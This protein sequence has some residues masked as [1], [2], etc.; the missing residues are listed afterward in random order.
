MQITYGGKGL[1]VCPAKKR[2]RYENVKTKRAIM[3]LYQEGCL[4]M[5]KNLA[6]TRV[7][8]NPMNAIIWRA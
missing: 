7:R 3:K 6:V 2:R 1:S 4:L 5:F 8:I